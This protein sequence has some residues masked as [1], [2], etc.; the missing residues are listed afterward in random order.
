MLFYTY[1]LVSCVYYVCMI[2]CVCCSHNFSQ[3][4]ENFGPSLLILFSPL[5]YM[6]GLFEAI[7]SFYFGF[8]LGLCML[9]TVRLSRFYDVLSLRFKM[10]LSFAIFGGH[11]VFYYWKIDLTF[12]FFQKELCFLSKAVGWLSYTVVAP[13][14]TNCLSDCLSSRWYPVLRFSVVN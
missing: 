10:G 14:S 3:I 9:W 11:P 12:W 1:V 4:S 13:K 6:F 8:H 5:C 7:F 2:Q